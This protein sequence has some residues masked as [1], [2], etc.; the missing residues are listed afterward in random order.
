VNPEIKAKW[1]A[2]LRSGEYQQARGAL[3]RA[4]TVDEE[5]NQ[6]V[7]H[8]CLGVLCEVA[9]TEGLDIETRKGSFVPTYRFDGE[10]A[11]LPHTIAEWAGLGPIASPSIHTDDGVEFLADLND[12]G[13]SFAEIADLIEEYL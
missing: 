6:V 11:L 5:G 7:G 3:K 13:K 1:V 4:I 8:C 9:I 10:S 12:D 2:A